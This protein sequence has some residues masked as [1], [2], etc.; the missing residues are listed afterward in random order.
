MHSGGTSEG[1]CTIL[2]LFTPMRSRLFRNEEIR[3]I[4]T[5]VEIVIGI[6]SIP[7]NEAH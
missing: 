5:T 3:F 4:H 7:L 1:Q 2:F 6:Q